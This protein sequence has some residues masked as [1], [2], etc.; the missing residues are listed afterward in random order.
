[1][2]NVDDIGEERRKREIKKIID[3]AEKCG[4][5][6]IKLDMFGSQVSFGGYVFSGDD[7]SGDKLSIAVYDVSEDNPGVLGFLVLDRAQWDKLKDTGDMLLTSHSKH[8][9]RSRK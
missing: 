6:G 7:R 8:I 5:V 4:D 2:S 9:A 1:M 3:E